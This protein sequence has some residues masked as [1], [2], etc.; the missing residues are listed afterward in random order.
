MKA[1][2][3]LPMVQVRLPSAERRR[4]PRFALHGSVRVTGREPLAA[5]DGTLVD[6]S[7]GGLRL[8]AGGGTNDLNPG[9][10]VDVEVTVKDVSDP[11]RP[12]VIHLRGHGAVVRLAE[13][14]GGGLEMALR[15]D[16]PL[17]LREYFSQVR[18]F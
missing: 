12:P 3:G 1:A 5:L 2:D 17:R 8:K 10:A 9:A 15:L 16:G 11:T 4:D 7:A 6:V 18:V 14:E 13:G